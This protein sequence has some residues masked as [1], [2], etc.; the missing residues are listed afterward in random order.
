MRSNFIIN[1]YPIGMGGPEAVTLRL[2]SGSRILHVGWAEGQ[3][4]IWVE[5]D[6]MAD[7][8]LEWWVFIIRKD[9]EA[10][11]PGDTYLGSVVSSDGTGHHVFKGK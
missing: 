11:Q 6:T 8:S 1:R 3:I 9:G 7:R 2:K 5:S 10:Y 4:C